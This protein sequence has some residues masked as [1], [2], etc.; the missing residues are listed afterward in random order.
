MI[1][2]RG[3]VSVA[4]TLVAAGVALAAATILGQDEAPVFRTTTELV[5]IDLQVIHKKTN[6]S[7]AALRRE[8][9]LV[10]EDGKPQK[11][12]FFSRDELPL[13]I[14][15][16]FDMT[17]TSRMVLKQLAAGARAALA[18]LKP[19]DEAA[20]MVYA[21]HGR[22]IDAFTTD[23]ERTAGAIERAAREHEDGGAY[24]NEAVWQAAELLQKSG[25]PSG[26]RVVVWLTDNLPNVAT[27]RTVHTEADAIRALH[28]TG[29]VVAP[30]LLRSPMALAVAGP[31]MA[32]EAPFRL[33]HPPGDAHKYAE[34]TG[35]Q[36]IGLAGKRAGERLAE[37]IDD[38]RS[39]YTVG[40][41]PSDE[42]PAG[43]FCKIHVALSP[44]GALRAKEW[45]VL[46]RAGYYRK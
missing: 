33:A 31:I 24:F 21:A 20:V 16:L 35:G 11:V 6:T 45:K 39:R 46:A 29:T 12:T 42:K 34:L 36:A 3:R 17:D 13:S 19:A 8:D 44:E 28:E 43:A 25:N 9:V 10:S 18:H 30:L 5:L 26:R 23:R 7:T 40:Y 15:M 4:T 1:A 2:P 14:M 32:I 22:V 37:L 38:L 27:G 41:R